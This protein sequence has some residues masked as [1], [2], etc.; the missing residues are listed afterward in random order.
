VCGIIRV[1]AMDEEPHPEGVVDGFATDRFTGYGGIALVLLSAD[2]TILLTNPAFEALFG[3]DGDSLA[4]RS[5]ET[6]IGNTL[7]LYD[8]RL[9]AMERGEIIVR[10]PGVRGTEDLVDTL[11]SLMPIPET[12]NYIAAFVPLTTLHA[13][14][15]KSI[16]TGAGGLTDSTATEQ[17]LRMIQAAVDAAAVAIAIADPQGLLIYVNGAYLDLW[18]YK[19]ADEVLGRPIDIFAH[20]DAEARKAIA[21]AFKETQ[22]RGFWI[23][24]HHL[25][26]RD[27]S[28]MDLLITT[29]KVLDD[30]GRPIAYMASFL[31]ISKIKETTRR[32]EMVQFAIDHVSEAIY[33]IAPDSSILYANNAAYQMLGYTPDELTAIKVV[34]LDP[35]FPP[36]RWPDHWDEVREKG[37]MRF[38]SAHR[39]KDGSVLPTEITVNHLEFEGQEY[40]FSFVRDITDRLKSEQRLH[41]LA[42][43]PEENPS[44]VLRIMKNGKLVY[45][46]QAAEPIL[47]ELGWRQGD[48]IPEPWRGVVQ[49][50]L[51]VQRPRS[52]N[53][54]T[55]DLVYQLTFAPVSKGAYL[56]IYGQDITAILKATDE[57]SYK[58]ARYRELFEN[59][60]NGVAV[61]EVV[62]D[63][64]DIVF[65]DFNRAAEEID[66][67]SRDILIGKSLFDYYPSVNETGI[68]D[69]IRRVW[70]TGNPESLPVFEY[71]DQRISGWRDNSL[72]RLPTGEVVV[73]FKDITA[74]RMA[75][76]A[77]RLSEEKFRDLY[78]FREMV[79]DNADIL[80]IVVDSNLRVLIWNK[81]A[82]RITR[83][84]YDEVASHENIW[85]LLIPDDIERERLITDVTGEVVS[86]GLAE[87]EELTIRD[88]NGQE[89]YI[90]MSVRPLFN[91]RSNLSAF[92]AIGRDITLQHSLEIQKGEALNQINRNLEQLAILNDHIRNPLQVIVSLAALENSENC[93]EVIGQAGEIDHIVRLLDKGWL[94]S[95]NVA[96]FL[97]KHH[98][99]ES[100][101][102]EQ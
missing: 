42:R 45:A 89:H 20:G 5:I 98:L 33:W 3:Y 29:S 44:P 27:S 94:E 79:I 78:Q 82:E 48:P 92:L 93:A 1:F 49:E 62:D 67:I 55:G 83:Y 2:G 9:K 52:V 12:W 80:I 101:T 84:S 40:F 68:P 25:F 86:G 102:K 41:D 43:F 4:G 13:D 38:E 39:R 21:L 100:E 15:I 91:T 96:N 22:D 14:N 6:I 99:T 8:F 70:R 56:N 65:R 24:E 50:T 75:E 63:G 71:R 18:G 87:R 30:S 11:C 74:Q 37:M 76:E 88:K 66:H 19:E 85:P 54:N 61:Y 51:A 10:S 46:N 81:A 35:Y 97:K 77:L 26:S 53:F 95:L 47:S 28:P 69:A 16:R 7:S 64:A 72:Y 60:G 90:A 34:E 73:V 17:T 59:M 58:E 32:L 57:L 31:N 36:D 23:G